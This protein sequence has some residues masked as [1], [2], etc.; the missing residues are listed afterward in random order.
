M[1]GCFL[2]GYRRVAPDTELK[3]GSK[4]DRS[5]E[6]GDRGVHG[7]KLDQSSIEGGGGE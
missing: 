3:G 5:L 6:E 7:L 2:E 4:E 1:A